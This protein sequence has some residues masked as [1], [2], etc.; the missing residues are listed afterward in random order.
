M[1]KQLTKQEAITKIIE[2]T[3]NALSEWVGHEMEYF[4]N[5]SS[6]MNVELTETE[7]EDMEKA[8]ILTFINKAKRDPKI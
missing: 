7:W 8:V 1:K 4:K 6:I 5:T 3:A 2:D